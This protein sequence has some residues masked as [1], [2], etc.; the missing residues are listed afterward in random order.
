MPFFRNPMMVAIVGGIIVGIAIALNLVVWDD[1]DLADALPTPPSKE[2][3]LG[4]T[5]AAPSAD[6]LSTP[7]AAA[8]DGDAVDTALPARIVPSFDVVRVNPGGSA[9]IAGRAE[10]G[11]EV[12]IYEGDRFIGS[13]TADQRGEWVFVPSEPLK[14]GNRQLSLRARGADGETVPS[15]QVVMV[16]VPES[17][18]GRASGEDSGEKSG[19]VESGGK[20]STALVVAAPSDGSSG[21]QVLQKPGS[22]VT[23]ILGVDAMDYDERGEIN[24]SGTATPGS[25]LNLYIDG[26]YIG[27]TQ[28][29]DRGRWRMV[30]ETL[31]KPGQYELRVD[32]V[33]DS[34]KVENRIAMPF[35][36]EEIKENLEP[37][38]FYVVQPGNSLWRIA[39]RA[40]GRGERYTLIFEA[41]TNQIRDP[42]LI[43]PGQVFSLPE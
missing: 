28:T 41:N 3:V 20:Q 24:V 39:R 27:T 35:V 15:D 40:Y 5:A 14:P 1:E 4:E 29:D 37:G 17:M 43:Y 9:V 26:T 16:I 31:I 10:P 18:A 33:D 8:P 11:A 42:D 23:P 36:R 12:D 6:Q 22:S 38:T 7:E 19:S 25:L 34:G 32:H 21:S 30:P 2:E 13:A